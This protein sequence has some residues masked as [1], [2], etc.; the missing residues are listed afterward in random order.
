[1]RSFFS[2]RST[3]LSSRDQES[4]SEILVR[5]DQILAEAHIHTT[6]S[7][8]VPLQKNLFDVRGV[9][10]VAAGGAFI[11]VR[12]FHPDR[13]FFAQLCK[14]DSFGLRSG[15]LRSVVRRGFVKY[16]VT[17]RCAGPSPPRPNS[18]SRSIR[19]VVSRI[20]AFSICRSPGRHL[21]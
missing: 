12:I 20:S 6:G 10:Q 1:M 2:D 18:R 19:K 14:V 5:H 13:L 4:L 15:S 3:K 16:M 21:A 11:A 17:N 8:V 9:R 7:H